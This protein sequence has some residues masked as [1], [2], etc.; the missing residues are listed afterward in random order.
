MKF[1]FIHAEKALHSIRVMCRVL[2]VSASGYYA[3]TRREPSLRTRRDVVLATHIRAVHRTSRGTYGSP[4]IHAQLHRDGFEASRKRIARLMREQ[5]I[6]AVPRRRF[7]RTTDSRHDLPIAPNVL[8]RDFTAAEPN[9]VW[10]TDMTYVWTWQGWMYLAVI[11]DL[12]SRRVVGWAVANHMRT[13]LVLCA[14][15]RA[16]GVR[17]PRAGLVHHSD[18]GSQYASAE[19]R[20]QLQARG[21]RCSMSRRGDCYDNAVIE[22]FFG[23]IKA[24]LLDR[25]PWA[26]H[27][28]AEAAIAEYIESFY[29]P[30]RLHSRLGYLAP[31]EF[32]RQHRQQPTQTA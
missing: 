20:A 10:V 3:W 5:G 16:L 18:R 22:S 26:T 28:E 23:T 14:L 13:E 4:R 29:N 27:S 9:R 6:A 2:H 19:Y 24:E 11:L 7:R 25:R 1:G 32:E 15:S 12:F 21:I 31:A 8:K 30:R 17:Q